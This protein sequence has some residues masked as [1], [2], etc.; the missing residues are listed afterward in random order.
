MLTSSAF[1]TTPL[2]SWSTRVENGIRVKIATSGRRRKAPD[3]A[4][5]T[6][7]PSGKSAFLDSIGLAARVA[8][9]TVL[10]GAEAGGAQLGL[11]VLAQHLVDER[12]CIRAALRR[13]HDG[14]PV[15]DGRLRPGGQ[16]DHV[17]LVGDRL[18][19]GDVDEA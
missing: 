2:P 9:R 6:S 14:D 19:V 11:A 18:R 8:G 12:H 17:D 13:V 15:P 5:A 3:T 4:A 16:L 10:G 7:R 1:V